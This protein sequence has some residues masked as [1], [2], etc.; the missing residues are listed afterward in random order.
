MTSFADHRTIVVSLFLPTSIAASVHANPVANT[1]SALSEE[2]NDS[3]VSPE[4][5]NKSRKASMELTASPVGGPLTASQKSPT[6]SKFSV[7]RPKHRRQATS[8]S[9]TKPPPESIVDDLLAIQKPNLNRSSGTTDDDDDDDN[10]TPLRDKANSFASFATSGVGLGAQDKAEMARGRD[11]GDV[12][13]DTQAQ[14]EGTPM[15]RRL[16]RKQS[17]VLP[18]WLHS[19]CVELTLWVASYRVLVDSI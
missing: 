4:V 13:I 7:Q 14:A 8:I 1:S 6:T 3:G 18:S 17:K 11:R 15:V 10:G 9:I 5:Q 19:L 16:S 2:K 12:H